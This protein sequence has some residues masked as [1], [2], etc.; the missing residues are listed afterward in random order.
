MVPHPTLNALVLL[1]MGQGHQQ[2]SY[3]RKIFA[4]A[5]SF[6]FLSLLIWHLSSFGPMH[7][8]P[9]K[10][11][12]VAFLY[13]QS[14]VVCYILQMVLAIRPIA[15]AAKLGILCCN[16]LLPNGSIAVGMAT[17]GCVFAFSVLH[18]TSSA[19]NAALVWV[20]VASD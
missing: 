16:C 11:P 13:R 12:C 14:S 4:M 3:S 15:P 19:G 7:M 20:V 6:A 8:E 1:S 10:V 5:S 17:V 2:E 18:L 9:E